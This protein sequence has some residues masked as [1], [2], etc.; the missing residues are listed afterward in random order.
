MLSRCA[1]GAAFLA[2]SATATTVVYA[3]DLPDLEGR[4]VTVVAE[5]TYPPLQFVDPKSGKAIGWEYDAVAEIADRLN[6]NVEYTT[7]SWDAMIQA[8]H[9]NQYDMAM[10]G[11]TIR[12]DRKEMVDF[13]DPY[14]HSEMLMLVRGDED[15]FEDAESFAAL[16]G[17]LIGSQPGTTPFYTAVYDVL[18]GDEQNPRIKLYETIGAAVQ[19]LR[20]GDVDLVLTD[21]TAANGYVNVSNGGLK[22]TGEPLGAEDFGFIFPVGS[23]LEAPVNAALA[24]MKADGTLEAL[25][26]KWFFDYKMGQ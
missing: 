2:V 4:T 3:N 25:N 5:N 26:Q 18:D 20:I 23:D 10:N 21:S 13:S 22:L 16:K 6:M 1:I 9:D 24:S 19:A 12:E 15:R 17:G 11:I 7:T 8:V 14:M